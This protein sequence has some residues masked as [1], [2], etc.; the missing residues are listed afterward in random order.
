MD[1][2]MA[3]TSSGTMCERVLIFA[4]FVYG[5]TLPI[6]VLRLFAPLREAALRLYEPLGHFLSCPACVGFW[7]GL[8]ASFT[9]FRVLGPPWDGFLGISVCWILHALTTKGQL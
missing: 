8:M 4:L 2:E 6:A 5:V 3:V 1:A 9:P 7:V